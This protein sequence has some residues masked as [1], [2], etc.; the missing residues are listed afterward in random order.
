MFQLL[1]SRRRWFLL[2]GGTVV[3]WFAS[4]V[5]AETAQIKPV[6]VS[7]PFKPTAFAYNCQRLRA[8]CFN[9]AL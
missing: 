9:L 2:M 8:S 3:G 6:D 5:K 7:D 4:R 1:S